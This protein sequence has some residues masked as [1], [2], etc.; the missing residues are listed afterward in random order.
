[1]WGEKQRL[2]AAQYGSITDLPFPEISPLYT[3]R[4]VLELAEQY[5]EQILSMHP[6]AVMCEGEY[7]F[8]YAVVSRLIQQNVTVLAACT[9]RDVMLVPSCAGNATRK[10]STF[11]FVCFRPY[12]KL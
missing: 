11:R 3:E 1:M 8:C 9:Q 5:A 7:T 6:A 10:I 4:Q 12:K 2:S